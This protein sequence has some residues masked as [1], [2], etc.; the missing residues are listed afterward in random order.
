MTKKLI[1][2]QM[3]TNVRKELERNVD[4]LQDMGVGGGNTRKLR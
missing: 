1:Q 2:T 4:E 3:R